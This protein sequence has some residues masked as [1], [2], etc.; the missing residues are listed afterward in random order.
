MNRKELRKWILSVSEGIFSEIV[1]ILLWE[2]AYLTEAS[3]TFSRDTWK[4]KVA[5]DRFL[6][7]VNYETIKNAL[8]RARKKG[9][10]KSVHH[11][12]AWPEI[13][14]E[15]KRRLAELIPHYDSRR[16]WDGRIYLITYDIPEGKKK[17]RELLREY[18]RRLGCGLVQ[19]SVW[20]TPYN[21]REV[22][23]NFIT[24]QSLS[25]NILIS[26]IGTDG[27]IGDEDLRTLVARIYRLTD[28]NKKYEEFIELY[29]NGKNIDKLQ[30]NFIYL[31]ILKEDPQL[32]FSLLPGDWLG[33]N[34]HQI[35][36]KCF[37]SYH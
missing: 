30:A 23:K 21:P 28:L 26:D 8:A 31:S 35:Y 37:S 10:I 3:T 9:Y 20:L 19:D 7:N 11:K 14:Q 16:A 33:D 24:E 1:D 12:K 34:A 4:A 15:G 18:L 6:E 27:S 13:T 22:L 36:N 25:G 17:L 2:I 29:E 5:A 32:P